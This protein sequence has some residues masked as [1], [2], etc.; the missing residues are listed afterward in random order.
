VESLSMEAIHLLHSISGENQFLE[1][2]L[3]ELIYREK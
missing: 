2:L 3:K 1:M